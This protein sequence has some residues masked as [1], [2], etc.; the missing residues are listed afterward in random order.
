MAAEELVEAGFRDVIEEEGVIAH[1]LWK[2][3]TPHKQ[4]VLRAVAGAE[5]GLTSRET[6]GRFS[7]PASGTVSNTAASLMEEEYLV[8]APVPPGYDF[9]SPFFRGWVVSRAL[10]DLGIDQPITWRATLG[11]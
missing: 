11:R 1:A 6:L 9:E 10:P 7:L 5:S 4:D 3:L 8:K 2:A